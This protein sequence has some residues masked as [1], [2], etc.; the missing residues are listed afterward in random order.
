MTG[1]LVLAVALCLAVPALWGW[2]TFALFVRLGLHRRLP[3]PK[4]GHDPGAHPAGDAWYY[5]I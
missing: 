2:L 4:V 1:E 3:V 5:Q